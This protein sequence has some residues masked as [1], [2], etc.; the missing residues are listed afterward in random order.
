MKTRNQAGSLF[1]NVPVNRFL[2][3]E[4]VSCS[5]E[6]AE[7]RMTVQPEHIQETGIVHGG[8][9]S[10]LADTAAVYALYPELPDDK[11]MTSIEFKINFLQPARIDA[12]RLIARSRVVRRGRK[13]AVC[14]VDVSQSD[15]TVA[16][17][18]FTYLFFESK[19]SS[20]A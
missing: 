1:N 20:S 16:K 6:G 8:L 19:S 5:K 7:V 2:G 15:R 13:V 9:L 3:F 11:A 14:D 18:L 10:A 17:G 12:G 4:L